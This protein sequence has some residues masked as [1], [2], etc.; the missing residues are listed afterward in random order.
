MAVGKTIAK[1]FGITFAVLALLIGGGLAYTYYLGPT[2]ADTVSTSAPAVAPVAPNIK[3]TKPPA[4]AKVG[5]SVSAL[6]SP[7]APGSNASVTIRTT[8]GSKCV[9]TV[10]YGQTA[11]TDSGL[12]PKTTDE[13]GAVSWTWTVGK[14]VPLGKWPVKVTCV[15]NA[16]SAVV[17]ADLVVEKAPQM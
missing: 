6:T 12:T 2:E 11:S 4:N 16:Q 14:D 15:Y 9:I 5:A 13:Y 17:Q 10:T 8:A 7:I 1:W 3:P